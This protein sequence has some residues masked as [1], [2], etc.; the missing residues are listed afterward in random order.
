MYPLDKWLLKAGVKVHC[1]MRRSSE[2]QVDRKS[3]GSHVGSNTQFP[4]YHQSR[5]NIF[6]TLFYTYIL[7]VFMTGTYRLAHE[8]HWPVGSGS[9]GYASPGV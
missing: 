7:S 4:K 9:M 8:S 1:C 6:F 3:A 5:T 2:I